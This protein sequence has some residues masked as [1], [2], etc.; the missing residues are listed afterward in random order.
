MSGLK[1][2]VF[3]PILLD[4]DPPE[5]ELFNLDDDFAN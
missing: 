1:P 2:T 3:P 5:L 4:L